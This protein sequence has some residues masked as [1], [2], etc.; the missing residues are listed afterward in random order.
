MSLASK[1]MASYLLIIT[2]ATKWSDPT[3]PSLRLFLPGFGWGG[4]GEAPVEEA[5]SSLGCLLGGTDPA[6]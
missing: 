4:V 5:S 6:V 3:L 2:V 1:A